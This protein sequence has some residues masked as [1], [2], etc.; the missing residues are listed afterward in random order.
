MALE[1]QWLPIKEVAKMLNIRADKLA[2]LARQKTIRSK[3]Y[4]LDMR[5]K[6]VEVNEVKRLFEIAK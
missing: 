2:R 6:L 1:E 3:D 5:V 4:P